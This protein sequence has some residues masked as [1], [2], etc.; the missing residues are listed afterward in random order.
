MASPPESLGSDDDGG[1]EE[2][3]AVR[4]AVELDESMEG[5]GD[6]VGPGWEVGFDGEAVTRRPSSRKAFVALVKSES[7]WNF[8]WIR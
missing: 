6:A 3:G 8:N 5:L 2:A 1:A 4:V 7:L